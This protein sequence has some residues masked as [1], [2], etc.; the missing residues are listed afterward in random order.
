MRTRNTDSG[1]G[2]DWRV[3]A[4]ED[5]AKGGSERVTMSRGARSGHWNAS[6]STYRGRIEHGGGERERA[7]RVARVTDRGYEA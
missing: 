3:S 1:L 4:W 5:E 6:T 7:E 2:E